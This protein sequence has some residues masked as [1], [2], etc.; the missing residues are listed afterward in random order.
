VEEELEFHASIVVDG[1]WWRWRQKRRVHTSWARY[2]TITC[3][4]NNKYVIAGC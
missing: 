3:W 2:T 1:D 4:K